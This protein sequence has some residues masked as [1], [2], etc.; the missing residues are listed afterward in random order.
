MASELIRVAS[1]TSTLAL[2]Q[3]REF[4]NAFPGV[5]YEIIGRPA[6]GDL[7]KDI[8]LLD[9]PP[10]D[11]F[12]REQDELVLLG[13]ADIAIHSAKDMPF[14][15]PDGLELIALTEAFDTSDS[16]VSRDNKTLAELPAG[17]R[18]ATSSPTRK[19]GLLAIRPELVV[20]GIR[21]TIEERI[22]QIDA[23]DY[24]ALIV[25]TCALKRLGLMHRVAEVLPFRT[26]PL[27][28]SLAVV[29]RKGNPL[30]SR[31]EMRDRAE[32][33]FATADARSRYGHVSITG[34]GP[35]NPDLLTRRATRA[36]GLADIIFYDDL[37]D[38]RELHRYT[39]EKVYVGKRKDRHSHSQEDI[40]QL[41]IDAARAGRRV[42]RLK[43]G[44]PMVFA[45]G[46]EEA[47]ALAQCYIPYEIIPGISTALAVASLT[48]IPLTHRGLAAS[49]AFVTGHSP[50]LQLPGTD[51]VVIYMGAANLRPIATNALAQGRTPETPVLLA[52]HVSRNNE[53][54]F[55]TTLGQL[56]SEDNNY[57]TPLIAVV[58]KVAGLGAVLP[59]KSRP[60][61]LVTGTHPGDY[62]RLGKVIH[63]PLIELKALDTPP[64][65]ELL[66]HHDWLI[67]T[68]RNSVD[69]FVRALL[70]EEKT[71][72][73]SLAGL[74]IVSVGRITSRTLLRYGLKPDLQATDESSEG[75]LTLLRHRPAARAVIPR[76]AIGLPALPEGLRKAGWKITEISL[77][78]NNLPEPTEAIDLTGIDTIVLTSP[79]CV[80]NF[81]KVYGQFPAE[82]NYLLRGRET[83]KRFE[84]EKDNTKNYQVK[85][86]LSGHTNTDAAAMAESTRHPLHHQ[87]DSI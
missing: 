59:A 40:H 36:L 74:R 69:F 57:P 20:A 71:D 46:G 55:F 35:G 2:L 25:A 27:Q 86:Q 52:A 28:G 82:K 81:K 11:L 14:P 29:G 80:T 68:S 43:G 12:T 51:T 18:I 1:R 21:G 64:L 22:A 87:H 30:F 6:W 4:F 37:L 78:T 38:A 85:L 24:D 63:Q 19:A 32:V 65:G 61:L 77:Y 13:E 5:A 23:G 31:K 16:L 39:A 72:L 15:L 33:N 45:H 75:I 7:R 41:M 56:A 54:R 83:E 44:D 79:S 8:S 62:D 48:G 73:R 26:H 3:V 17:A 66:R 50:Q 58:G 42:V 67:F 47:L 34:F 70:K 76:S 9:N 84:N 60:T 53:Q 49:V 10:A